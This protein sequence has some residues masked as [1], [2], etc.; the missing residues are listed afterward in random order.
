MSLPPTEPD[1]PPARWQA[2]MTAQTA[3]VIADQKRPSTALG[4][5]VLAARA[6]ADA[7]PAE[8]EATARQLGEPA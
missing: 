2:A 6:V 1:Q 7:E 5:I 4:R 8:I 3:P